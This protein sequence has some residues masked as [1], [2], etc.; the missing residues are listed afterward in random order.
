[1]GG[2]NVYFTIFDGLFNSIPATNGPRCVVTA[3]AGCQVGPT[4]LACKHSATVG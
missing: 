2:W 4:A 3:R 1:M